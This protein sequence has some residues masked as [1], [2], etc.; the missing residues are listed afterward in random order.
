MGPTHD[1]YLYPKGSPDLANAHLH[2]LLQIITL[3]HFL[4]PNR[5]LKQLTS[6]E[7]D[8]VREA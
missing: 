6:K 1:P 2:S 4:Q 3:E 7:A 8:R 5:V